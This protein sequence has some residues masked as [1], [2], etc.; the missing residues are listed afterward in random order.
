MLE[1]LEWLLPPPPD[2]RQRIRALREAIAAGRLEGADAELTALA[3]FGLG[4][5]QLEQLAKTATAYAAAAPKSSLRRIRL[6]LLGAGTLD[7]IASAV[8]ATGLRHNLLIEVVVA[9]YGS[10]LQAACDPESEFRAQDPEF[11]LVSS[12]YRTLDLASSFVSP[13]EASAKVEFAASTL[14]AILDGLKGWVKAGV[15]FQTVT[16][17]MEPLFGSLDLTQGQSG[18]A[19]VSELNRRIAAWAQAGDTTVVDVARAATWVG[20]EH[21]EDAALWHMAKMPFAMRLAPFCLL[22]YLVGLRKD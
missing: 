12:D 11:V 22:D 4:V 20:L 5:T 6:G 2:F 19:M 16:P 15:L 8:T 1:N 7:V 17:P 9:D 13:E 10:A 14:R 21:W 3:N 18:Y